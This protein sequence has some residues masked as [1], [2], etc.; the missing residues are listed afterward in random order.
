ME[1]TTKPLNI[2]KVQLNQI[3]K[4]LIKQHRG[5]KA[6]A[7]AIGVHYSRL[8]RHQNARESINEFI[9]F[10]EKIRLGLKPKPSRDKFAKMLL[11][12]DK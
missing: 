10:L 7:S 8:S 1:P 5:L 3:V 6:A 4:E 11:G 12:V 2:N 9:L